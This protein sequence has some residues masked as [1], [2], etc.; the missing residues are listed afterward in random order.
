[1]YLL[2]RHF[3][4]SAHDALFVL[5]AW[6]IDLLLDGFEEEQQAMNETED[7]DG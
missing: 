5:P 6:E 4:I 1:M 7:F 2:R 3:G